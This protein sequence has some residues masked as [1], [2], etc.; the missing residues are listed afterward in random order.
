MTQRPVIAMSPNGRF[1]IYQ[2]S[3]GLY[4]R[5]M[6]RPGGAA[7]SRHLR[8]PDKSIRLAGWP[9]GRLFCRNRT[10]EEDR[11]HRKHTGHAVCSDGRI[12]R[13][14]GRRQHDSVRS[15]RWHQAR[16]RERRHSGTHHSG[17]RRRT[18]VR[19]AAAARRALGD[20]QRHQESGTHPVGRGADRGAVDLLGRA[21]GRR[22]RRER[23]S[24]P[25]DGPSR[26]R[27]TRRRIRGRIR[28]HSPDDQGRRGP[29][30]SGGS[31]DGG[32]ECG[33]VEL[34]VSDQGTLV[35]VSGIV[36][37]GPS[38]GCNRNGTRRTNRFYSGRHVRRSASLADGR[39]VLATRD[40]DIWIYDLASGRS[41]RVTRDGTSQM[42]V[43]NPSGT[44]DGLFVRKEWKPGGLGRVVRRER[45][46][47]AT[48]HSRRAGS[49]R[50][51]VAR[52]ANA[53]ASS[54]SS[55]TTG[56]NPHA[57]DGSRRSKPEVFLEGDFNAEG[58]NFSRDGRY[59]AYLSPET[60]Q[61]RNLHSAL[62]G[63]SGQV[64]VSVGGGSQAD[65][66]E[67]RRP[68]LQEPDRRADVC[69]ARRHRADAEGR[70]PCAAL[71]RT[72]YVPSSGSPRPQ[73]DVAA[74]GQRL[75]MLTTRSR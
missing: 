29:A 43:W 59:V 40:G 47:A 5:S 61:Q 73:Y 46:T 53:D 15:E 32:C 58:A 1:F 11:R 8:G 57:V 51:V 2:T 39:R 49:C 22:S 45:P 17:R 41:S 9:M 66:G 50:F 21:K 20:V 34:R 62:P 23:R 30:R 63:S 33:R 7:H 67:K 14:L 3:E 36:A 64:T 42:G 65:L 55:R 35:F 69:G 26:L 19:A 48:D 31:A 56:A 68:L 18:N 72:L 75:L 12:R 24:L 44:R 70:S 6:D 10:A 54:P 16:V 52:R 74:D 28:P 60:G 4:L 27:V 25:A 13:Q 71:S 37:R 38:S